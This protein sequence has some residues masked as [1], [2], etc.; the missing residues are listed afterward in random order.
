MRPYPV[1]VTLALLHAYIG[2]RVL[3][4]LGASVLGAPGQ[5]LLGGVLLLSAGLIPLGL[6]GGRWV[7]QPWADR[8]SWAGLLLMGLF[9]SLLVMT[10]VRDAVFLLLWLV[11]S[12][13]SL[14]LPPTAG[15]AT[16]AIAFVEQATH[17]SP[18]ADPV[19]QLATDPLHAPAYMAHAVMSFNEQLDRIGEMVGV[20]ILGMLLWAVPWVPAAWW[21]VPLVLLLVRPLSVA[22][23][24]AGSHR[25]SPLQ[26]RLIGWFGIRGIGSLYYL[27]YAL[28]HGLPPEH[29]QTFVA[30]TVAVVVS[31]IVVH[32]ISVT[33][34]MALYR[35]RRRG[36]NDK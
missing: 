32:G 33:P 22:V 16:A 13:A 23:G 35:R 36:G 17:S 4:G 10:L 31:S 12:A 30:L 29:A 1:V 21:F 3:P 27:S 9:S 25:T 7:R 6:A 5:W 34:L 14:G 15:A 18:E 2:W 20:V 11:N 8:L 19:G 28:N 24:L 26:R